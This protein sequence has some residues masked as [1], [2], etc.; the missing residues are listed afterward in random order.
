MYWDIESSV[1]MGACN[2][3]ILL[4]VN[5]I[6]LTRAPWNGHILEVKNAVM[7][8]VQ[9]IIYIVGLPLG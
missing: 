2:S 1:E 4:D 7:C 8:C 6:T 9:F 3:Y 5:D